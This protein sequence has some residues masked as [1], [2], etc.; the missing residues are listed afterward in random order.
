MDLHKTIQDFYAEKEM[1]ERVIASLEDLLRTA[2]SGIPS[3]Q[4]CGARRGRKSMGADER[5][6]VAARM[7]RYWEGRRQ[8]KRQETF[9]SS[10]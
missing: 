10:A 1:L 3:M 4:K 6:E 9:G 8:G 2:G 7:R 5:Q